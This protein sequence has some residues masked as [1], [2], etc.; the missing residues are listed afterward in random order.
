MTAILEASGFLPVPV[1]LIHLA[2]LRVLP[3]L[4][5]ED[6]AVFLRQP[7]RDFFL[8]LSMRNFSGLPARFAAVLHYL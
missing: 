4:G 2:L 8:H 7:H 1:F 5:M 3:L 6:A